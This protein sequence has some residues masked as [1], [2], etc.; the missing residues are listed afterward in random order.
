MICSFYTEAVFE[1]DADGRIFAIAGLDESIWAEMLGVFTGIRI[2]A[3]V[4]HV[5]VPSNPHL[6]SDPRIDLFALPFY[7]GLRAFA[8]RVP[9]LLAALW[10]SV[11]ADGAYLL[12]LPGPIGTGAALALALRG[13]RFA[14]QLVGDPGAVLSSQTI[15]SV[16]RRLRGVVMSAT[17]WACRSA[18]VISY[19]TSSTLQRVYPP[20]PDATSFAC[21][22]I[23]LPDSWFADRPR[24]LS[25]PASLFLCGSLAQRYKGADLLIEAVR[26]LQKTGIDLTAVIAG[27]GFYR[28]EL[29]QQAFR[30]GVANSVR[31][32]GAIPP[33]EIA[34]QLDDCTIFVI[35]SRT[36][37]LPR[38]L[39]EALAKGV[40]SIGSQV[41]GIPELL[42]PSELVPPEDAS[43][44][45]SAINALLTDPA[46]YR[47]VS[48][49]ALRRAQAFRP[50]PLLAARA[51]FYEA[52]RASGEPS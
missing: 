14:V 17:R 38:A 15:S 43:A 34:K 6:L 10:R 51:A 27:D 18:T 50:A 39:I 9:R 16:A 37:G 42:K 28:N 24:D 4:R 31:F 11:H 22:D 33:A 52:V 35:P 46:R 36:E 23:S 19:V 32:L 29:E 48:E 3:R 8:W 21:S 26:L 41:G 13:R 47:E 45:A 20:D 25:R 40:P 44:L 7:Q 30:A 1:Q 12:R 2:V 5:A 49:W